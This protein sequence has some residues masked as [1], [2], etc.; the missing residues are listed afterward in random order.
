[1]PDTLPN[2]LPET[3][4]SPVTKEL[5]QKYT[6]VTGEFYIHSQNISRFLKDAFEQIKLFEDSNAVISTAS[7]LCFR[8]AGIFFFNEEKR[9]KIVKALPHAILRNTECPEF[10][11]CYLRFVT[12]QVIM[13]VS[14]RLFALNVKDTLPHIFYFQILK[15]MLRYTDKTEKNYDSIF[16][17]FEN[18]FAD[19]AINL[20]TKMEI[21][22]I[23]ILNNMAIR[24]HEMLDAIRANEIEL[25]EMDSIDSNDSLLVN[26]IK[27]RVKSIYSDSQNVH[28]EEINKGVIQICYNLLE[29]FSGVPDIDV[30]KIEEELCKSFS[31]KAEP[32]KEALKRIR[33]DESIYKHNGVRFNIGHIFACVWQYVQDHR[34]GLE[35]TARLVEELCEMAGYCSSGH[36]SRFVSVLQGFAEETELI[37]TISSKEQA[38]H[39]ISHFLTEECKKAGDEILEYMIGTDQDRFYDF[40]ESV[41][42]KELDRLLEEGGISPETVLGVVKKFTDCSNWRVEKVGK[43]FL[44]VQGV[45]PRAVADISTIEK[46]PVLSESHVEIKEDESLPPEEE[47]APEK[48]GFLRRL[49]NWITDRLDFSNRIDG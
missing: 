10:R 33:I 19:P 45:D 38:V 47:A 30:F 42:N 15:Y 24:G 8:V 3:L 13:P 22:D 1:M 9:D 14:N 36:L 43:K 44:I 29:K 32:L 35:M 12:E 48:K 21:A 31:D 25:A 18:I 5:I 28:N 39:K 49:L 26:I 23:H 17:D 37:L 40:V 6:N 4:V 34:H 2:N 27:A 46:E 16:E 20:K 41:I 7:L 11:I